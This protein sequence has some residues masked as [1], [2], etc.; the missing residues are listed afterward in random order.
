MPPK[1]PA[2]N[3]ATKALL[4]TMRYSCLYSISV[5]YRKLEWAG[6]VHIMLSIFVPISRIYCYP[7][8]GHSLGLESG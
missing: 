3:D 1:D 4:I 8:S 5:T 2:I 7:N 6:L